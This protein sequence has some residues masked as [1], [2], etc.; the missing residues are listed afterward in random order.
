[1]AIYS[2]NTQSLIRNSSK[3]TVFNTRS[4]MQTCFHNIFTSSS[5][6]LSSNS[7]SLFPLSLCF[8]STVFLGWMGKS[9][10]HKGWI[11]TKIKLAIGIDQ[12][13]LS[14]K[15]AVW[16]FLIEFCRFHTSFFISNWVL[17]VYSVFVYFQ[18]SYDSML[19][20]WQ[21]KATELAT[22]EEVRW[23]RQKNGA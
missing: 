8:S 1:M 14:I 6:S 12:I 7:L 2:I 15:N 3:S 10:R 4:C 16:L 13:S 22:P 17:C 9:N 23:D 19:K 21:V 18:N 5:P 20:F 11:L